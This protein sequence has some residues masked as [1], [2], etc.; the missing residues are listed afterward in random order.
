V[1]YLSGEDDEQDTLAPRFRRAGAEMSKVAFV[2]GVGHGDAEQIFS[3][4]DD[5]PRLQALIEQRRPSFI[6]IDPIA[7][8]LGTDLD[9][10]RDAVVR[11]LL[12]R[13]SKL[14]AR[15]D[16]TI[17][18]VLHLNKSDNRKIIHRVMGSLGFVAAPRSVLAVGTDP[19]N[20][21]R[22]F[23]IH[24][25]SNLAPKAP[26][27]AFTISETGIGYEFDPVGGTAESLLAG[28]QPGSRYEQHERDTA[29][30]FLRDLLRDGPRPAKEIFADAEHNGISKATL[31]RAKEDL[32]VVAHK[33]G[34]TGWYWML[35]G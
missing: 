28:D 34:T 13:L 5:L 32:G 35:P 7:S 24:V 21:Q 9:T 23:L 31:R 29:K 3:L 1:V 17:A 30:V 26:H 2:T 19:E 22:R 6:T 33:H 15:Y 27:L 11:A 20:E 25:K 4:V 10:H 18:V 16:V 8:F 14:A 12:I